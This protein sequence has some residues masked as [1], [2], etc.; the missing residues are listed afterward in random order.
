MYVQ[1]CQIDTDLEILIPDNYVEN[2]SERL[3]LYK[4]LDDIESEVVLQKFIEKLTDRFGTPPLP[5]LALADTLRLRWLAQE[6]GFEK[7]LLKRKKL[8]CY[9]VSKPDSP[10][11]ESPVFQKILAYVKKH[12]QH[13]NMKENNN[14]KLIYVFENIED[15][16]QVILELRK[17]LEE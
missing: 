1:D 3:I 4:E 13:G 5:V 8:I 15:I 2:I 7:I 14:R 11:Y 16:S 17:I 6:L 10:Y 12:P 9:F